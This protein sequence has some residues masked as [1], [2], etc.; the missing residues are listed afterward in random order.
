[1]IIEPFFRP[2][3]RVLSSADGGK[4]S[5]V[6]PGAEEKLSKDCKTASTF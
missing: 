4:A 5:F 6:A 3:T 2:T 1:M